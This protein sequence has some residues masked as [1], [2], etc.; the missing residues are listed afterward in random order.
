MWGRWLEEFSH[1]A[2]GQRIYVPV[3]GGDF[4]FGRVLRESSGYYL[5]GVEPAREDRDGKP[6]ELEVELNRKGLSVR[7]RQWVIVPAEK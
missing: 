3:G 4:A 6:R 1:A 7:S 5:L 2:G